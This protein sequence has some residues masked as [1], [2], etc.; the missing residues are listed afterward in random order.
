MKPVTVAF[1]GE[2][3]AFS[4]VA[5]LRYFGARIR[6]IPTSSFH[7]VFDSVTKRKSSFGV[8]PIENSLF[9]SVHQNYDLLGRYNLRIV[10]EIKLRIVHALMVNR[11][12]TL[13]D[14]KFVYSHPQALGQCEN[15]LERMK[16][17]EIVAV[18]DTAGAAKMIKDGRR[19]DAAAVAGVAA[20]RRYGLATLKVGIE[21]DHRNFTRFLILSRVPDIAKKKAK[22][23]IL[24]TTR[25]VPAALFQAIGAF[26]LRGIDLF[27]IESRPIVGK[28]WEYLFYLD[29]DGSVNETKCSD[30][31]DQLRTSAAH[32][33]VLGSYAKG[34]TVGGRNL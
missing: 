22:T 26:A 5:A 29:F 24:F 17:R 3:G 21:N 34:R 1:Q 12:V 8:I 25:N 4:E 7:H 16:G 32:V 28:P 20:A 6:T 27:K 18:Y 19:R 14:V 13:R 2:H 9:G 30:A 23:S 15:F 11:G 31:L 10:G 33:K